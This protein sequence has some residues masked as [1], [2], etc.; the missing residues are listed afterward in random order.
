MKRLLLAA[1]GGIAL[2]STVAAAAPQDEWVQQ[3]RRQIQTA[4]Q[5]LEES[6]FSLTHQIYTG[7]LRDDAETMV[8]LSLDIGT[9][10]AI[11]GA[12]DNDCTDIDLTLYDPRGNQVD[13]DIEADDYPVVTVEPSRSGTYRVK[14][15]MATC[16]A[17]PCR[18][19]VGVFGR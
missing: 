10:Y 3:V 6:G 16:S 5:R 13:I 15:T 19:G 14:V 12:C 9:S 7:S 18:Y 17:E 1:V 4:G 11:M 8:S 2:L